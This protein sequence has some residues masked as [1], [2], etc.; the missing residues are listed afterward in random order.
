MVWELLGTEN[1]NRIIQDALNRCTFPFEL[2]VPG[3]Q[4][5]QNKSTIP[6]E[7]GDLSVYGA[8][9]SADPSGHDHVHENGDTAHPIEFRNRILGLAWYSG[10]VSVDISLEN[11]EPLAQEVFLSEGAHMVDFFYMS[12]EQRDA[13]WRAYHDGDDAPHDHGWFDVGTYADWA[14]E[15][16]M[17]TFCLAYSDIVP[18]MDYFT[19][20]STPEVVIV[21]RQAL[22]GEDTDEELPAEPEVPEHE[23]NFFRLAHSQVVHDSHKGIRQDIW[24]PSLRAATDAGLRPCGVCKPEDHRHV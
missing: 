17:N 21:T 24:Y 8:R 13:I 1:Q 23:H 6:V 22:T 15:S 12:D 7:W 18:Q 14:G 10:K 9:M 5:Q 3:L 16:F 19:H 11:D 2:L 20:K 4:A